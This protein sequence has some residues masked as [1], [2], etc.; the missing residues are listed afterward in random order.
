MEEI[1]VKHSIRAARKHGGGARGRGVACFFVLS[2]ILD[3][4]GCMEHLASEFEFELYEVGF[5]LHSALDECR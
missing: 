5:K 3:C 4:A 1:F 2:F